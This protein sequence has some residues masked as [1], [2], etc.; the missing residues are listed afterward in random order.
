MQLPITDKSYYAAV[1]EAGNELTHA[2]HQQ[3]KAMGWHEEIERITDLDLDP[4]LTAK[5]RMW[6][7][8]TK[9]MLSTTELAE[10][11]EGLRKGIP[12]THLEQYPM[13][14]VELADCVIRCFDQA[15]HM[16]FDL[17]EII[18]AK[19]LYNASREDHQRKARA[20]AGGKGV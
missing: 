14:A 6:Y 19:L 13:F 8:G 18:A 15:G 4:S 9:L 12:D 5:I 1:A 20:A 10:A 16:E 2:C 7:Q 17:G 11:M 3:A